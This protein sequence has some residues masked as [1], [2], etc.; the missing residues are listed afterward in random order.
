MALFIIDKHGCRKAKT[1][2]HNSVKNY[3]VI[4][5]N[6]NGVDI[7]EDSEG[8]LWMKMPMQRGNEYLLYPMIKEEGN[9]SQDQQSGIQSN[10]RRH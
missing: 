3:K 1:I 5:T 4:D 8:D 10:H 7:L 2:S 9:V 6:T